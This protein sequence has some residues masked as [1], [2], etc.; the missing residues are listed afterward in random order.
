MREGFSF[1]VTHRDAHSRARVGVLRTPHG[2]V[3][4]PVYCPVGTLATVK[5][6]Q[7]EDLEMAG[8]S[9]VLANTYHLMLRPG[10]DRVA[11]LGGLHR[12]MAW[13]HPTFTDSGGFQAFSLGFAK[14][15]GVGKIGG[16]FP[17]E[18]RAAAPR[19]RPR[20]AHGGEQARGRQ[21]FGNMVRI[22]EDGVS[23]R[24]HLDGS[25]H[26]L[27]PERSIQLQQ[28]LGADVIVAF[29]ECTSP[30]SDHAY[31]RRAMERTHRWAERSLSAHGPRAPQ[32]LLGIVQGGAYQDLRLESTRVI[33]AMPFDAFAIGGS[34]GQSKADMHQVLEW[35]VPNLPD[36]RFRHLLGIGDV[37]DLFEC[38]ERGVDSFDCVIPTRFARHGTLFVPR[39]LASKRRFRLNINNAQYS[40][41]VG[42]IDPTC[43]CP[44]CRRYSRAYL[45][46]LF[47]AEE[48]LGVR[49]ASLHNIWFMQRLM[50]SIRDAIRGGTFAAL[51]QHWLG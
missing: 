26:R 12:F 30:L 49:L 28:Q 19:V 23:F 36:H 35:T 43:D 48:I 14:E 31:T 22:D 7:A 4:T 37:D 44:A 2:D 5:T 3:P 34:L 27:T 6:L 46:H 29:D 11:R 20:D 50:A 1:T 41:D 24:S 45:H 10:A 21:N 33:A 38:V 17:A 18:P 25:T 16:V 40:E 47:R 8:A 15:H 13:P 39:E 42:P 51:K 32:A 9:M